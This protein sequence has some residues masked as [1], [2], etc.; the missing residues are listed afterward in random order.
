MRHRILQI[1]EQDV[2]AQMR[3]ED[4]GGPVRST[5]ANVLNSIIA[6]RSLLNHAAETESSEVAEL[7]Q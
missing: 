5:L 6:A 3:E 4:E 1:W 7:T 2:R